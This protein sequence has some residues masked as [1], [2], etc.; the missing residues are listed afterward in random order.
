MTPHSINLAPTNTAIASRGLHLRAARV[1]LIYALAG[2]TWILLSD[3][4]VELLFD[5]VTASHAA[6]SIKGI[7]FVLIT[8]SLIYWLAFRNLRA[9]GHDLLATQLADTRDMLEAISSNLA[10]AIFISDGRNR[11]IEYCNTA[12]TEMFGYSANEM[13]GMSSEILHVDRESFEQF[14]RDCARALN[15][16]GVYRRQYILRRKSGRAFDTEITISNV[17]D[18]LGWRA[19]IVAIVHDISNR[20][21]TYEALRKSEQ[22][23]R[24]LAENTLDVIW[25]I[26]PNLTITYINP[27]ITQLTGHTPDEVVGSSIEEF[28]DEHHLPELKQ[29][30]EQEI[31][32]GPG[33]TGILVDTEA[34]RKDGSRV[35][36]EI[37]GR[38]LFDRAGKVIGLQGA[39]RDISERL[40]YEAQ[41]REAQ[42]LE[43][44]GTLAAG[45]AHEVNNPIASVS[46]FAE[47]ISRSDEVPEKFR[48]FASKIQSESARVNEI[49][50]NLLGYARLE[51]EKAP[52]PI[53]IDDVVDSTLPL[54]QGVLRRDNI[55][56]DTSLEDDLPPITGRRQ[57]IQQVLMNLLTNARDALNARY[58]GADDNKR[59]LLSASAQRHD[60]SHWIRIT[61]EDHGMGIPQ[62]LQER[63]FDP[64]YTTKPPGKGTG[65][66]LWLV[67]SIVENHQGHVRIES[68]PGEYTRFHVDIPATDVQSAGATIH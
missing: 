17:N 47:L 5:E 37:N 32:K 11:K 36:V 6:Q 15:R 60:S 43:A 33:T 26:D 58:P 38:V 30:I 53:A 25:S 39:T 1:A 3:Q 22:T 42:K 51:D 63:V 50:R 40:N 20:V 9:A 62:D 65:L 35:A 10:D 67:Y 31:A 66:G 2:A 64:F 46:G 23:Y 55:A 52:S 12:A 24:L 18:H 8:A 16:D 4:T 54:I 56:L 61:I 59:L 45:I 57:Q 44:I 41:L 49:V 21:Q 14:G 68:E 13:L 19:G 29:T 27:A 7:L 28:F 48:D 34:V